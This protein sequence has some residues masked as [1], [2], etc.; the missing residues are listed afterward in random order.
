MEI[1]DIRHLA[2]DEQIKEDVAGTVLEVETRHGKST[3]YTGKIKDETG[4][5]DITFFHPQG[6]SVEFKNIL[7]SG[8][9]KKGSYEG[10]PKITVFK[11]AKIKILGNSE[12]GPSAPTTRPL[13][14]ESNMHPVGGQSFDGASYHVPMKKMA[15]H[16]VNCILYAKMIKDKVKAQGVDLEPGQCQA[17]TSSLFIE[18]NKHGHGM[19]APAMESHPFFSSKT[20]PAAHKE[21]PRAKPEEVIEEESEDEDEDVP[22]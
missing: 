18:G 5:C 13:A 21:P 17:I 9:M 22:F 11:N 10:A 8:G 3:F 20:P 14:D 2:D 12:V 15:L 16:M 19:I 7:I 4:I 1:K 6:G